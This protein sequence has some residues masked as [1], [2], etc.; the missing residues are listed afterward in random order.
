[1][2]EVSSTRRSLSHKELQGHWQ[3]LE[4]QNSRTAPADNFVADHPDNY[5]EESITQSWLPQASAPLAWNRPYTIEK[6]LSHDQ[7]GALWSFDSSRQEHESLLYTGIQEQQYDS[8][9]VS[10][11]YDLTRPVINS[12]AYPTYASS[13]SQVAHASGDVYPSPTPHTGHFQTSYSNEI[14]SFQLESRDYSNYSG[15]SVQEKRA[16]SWP[17]LSEDVQS[18][19]LPIKTGDQRKESSNQSPAA[20]RLTWAI[21]EVPAVRRHKSH[22]STIPKRKSL[23]DSI[24]AQSSLVVEAPQ[25][26]LS[27]LVDVFEN[28]PGALVNVKRRKK[29]DYQVRKAA[30]EV[31]K[32]GACHQCRFRKRTVSCIPLNTLLSELTVLVFYW[33]SMCF[34]PETRS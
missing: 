25:K 27:E 24:A 26:D 15:E 7:P 3:W 4:Q 29:L 1:M 31:R 34:V 11:V 30:R 9:F 23:S 12:L 20:L 13:N 28:V 33:Y 17:P 10:F 5:K 2:T 32:A 14:S 16:L 6:P 8:G 19:I 18:H 21:C 22:P